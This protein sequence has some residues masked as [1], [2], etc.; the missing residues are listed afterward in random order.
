[1]KKD[2]YFLFV[3]NTCFKG[4][5]VYIFKNCFEKYCKEQGRRE[6][7]LENIKAIMQNAKLSA[8]DAMKLLNISPEEQ[9]KLLPLL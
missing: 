4:T 2:S 7:L 9:Q 3:E 8:E 1:M 6:N 5:C